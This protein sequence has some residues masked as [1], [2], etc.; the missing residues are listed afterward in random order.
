MLPDRVSNPA[1]CR[2]RFFVVF[3]L[4]LEKRQGLF[5]RAE[6]FIRI[7]MVFNNNPGSVFH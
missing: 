1:F 6:M 5:I 2:F 3:L 7:N 4:I